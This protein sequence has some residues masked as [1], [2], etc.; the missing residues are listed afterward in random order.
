M[1]LE[2]HC[3]L[4]RRVQYVYL[5]LHLLPGGVYASLVSVQQKGIPVMLHLYQ[6][7]RH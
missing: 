1:G 3:L 6:G 7:W 5:H 2:G 4:M